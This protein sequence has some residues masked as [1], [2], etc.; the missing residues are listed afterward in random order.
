MQEEKLLWSVQLN[1]IL[2]E[3]ISPTPSLSIIPDPSARLSFS[4]GPEKQRVLGASPAPKLPVG[5]SRVM[6]GL[7]GHPP[8]VGTASAFGSTGKHPQ[9]CFTPKQHTE[10]KG[11]PQL[12][13][14]TQSQPLHPGRGEP[15]APIQLFQVLQQEE[16]FYFFSSPPPF[17]IDTT[18]QTGQTLTLGQGY[19][20]MVLSHGQIKILGVL[21]NQ[22]LGKR[23]VS[24]FL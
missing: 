21:H 15:G 6:G 13:A 17:F 10:P 2:S 16:P 9:P 3:H 12:A 14:G 23:K 4:P 24:F 18:N 20:T 8:S 5:S 22:V 7:E 19:F 11:A 1:L